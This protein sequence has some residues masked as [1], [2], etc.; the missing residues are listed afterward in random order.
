MGKLLKQPSTKLL[1]QPSTPPKIHKKFK[2][3]K[4]I[5]QTQLTQLALDK[6]ESK[7]SNFEE[8]K[9]TE[10]EIDKKRINED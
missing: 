6:L 7:K 3:E 9:Q 10:D 1:K 2:K 4:K 8:K 5:T